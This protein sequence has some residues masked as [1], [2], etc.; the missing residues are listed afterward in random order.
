MPQ[1]Q[2]TYPQ[3]L[4]QQQQAVP[5]QQVMAATSQ[6]RITKSAQQENADISKGLTDYFN[7]NSMPSN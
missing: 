7:A 4:M 6:R 2:L 1:Q 5:M 3:P